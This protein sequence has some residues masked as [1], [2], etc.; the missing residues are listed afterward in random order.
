MDHQ[1]Q[2]FGQQQNQQ[3]THNPFAFHISEQPAVNS[4]IDL[5][6]GENFQNLENPSLRQFWEIKKKE[7]LKNGPNSG[8]EFHKFHFELANR[9]QSSDVI[10]FWD[11]YKNKYIFENFEKVQNYGI[12]LKEELYE[13][14]KNLNEVKKRP[15][16]KILKKTL[17]KLLIL[18]FGILTIISLVK[19]Y[20]KIPIGIFVGIISIV[21][22]IIIFLCYQLWIYEENRNNWMILRRREIRDFF[23]RI[24]YVIKPTGVMI[25]PS[26]YTSYITL[27]KFSKNEEFKIF[28]KEFRSFGSA[29]TG[30]LPHKKPKEDEISAKKNLVEKN[31]EKKFD[32]LEIYE[33]R[34][35][36]LSRLEKTYLMGED[37]VRVWKGA[38]STSRCLAN[39]ENFVEEEFD[40]GDNI[41]LGLRRLG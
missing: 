2:I 17:V 25:L 20:A 14:Q 31:F 28:E 24:N 16:E 4:S 13:L 21:I 5:E 19:F 26:K 36:R 33:D 1:N 34:L 11:S 35:K 40:L 6:Q 12:F 32:G 39:G 30:H 15:L 27:K 41:A 22:L 9:H 18:T 3:K 23:S 10:M 8:S 37:N 7:S 38:S 29:P